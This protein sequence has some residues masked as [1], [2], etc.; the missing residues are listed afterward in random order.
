MF[1]TL[2]KEEIDKKHIKDLITS[3]GI[4]PEEKKQP[5]NIHKVSISQ[6]KL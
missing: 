1:N 4:Y 2:K 6:P 3:P 5:N